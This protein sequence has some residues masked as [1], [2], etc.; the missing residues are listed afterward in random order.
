MLRA[1]SI[2]VIVGVVVMGVLWA[3][4]RQLIYF[5]GP[6]RPPPVAELLP[7]GEEVTLRTSDGLRL[8]AWLAPAASPGRGVSVLVANGNAGDR[9]L[10]AS[11]AR[12][13]NGHGLSVLLF[14]Y[15]GYGG[16]PGSPTERGLARDVRAGYR[17][18][19]ERTDDRILFYGE[20]LGAAVVTELATEHPPAGLVLR[21]PF[22][23]LAAVG[24]THYPLLPVRTLLRDRYPLIDHLASVRVPT[25]VVYGAADSIIPA[26]Q[27]RTVAEAAP[28][29]TT[30]VEI[31]GA[32]HNDRSLLDGPE[33]I[34]AVVELADQVRR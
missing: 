32:D 26:A 31:P 10:R 23:D 12:A 33:L 18:L 20:S 7:A 30:T 16:N 28:G 3:L 34:S 14:D 11:L 9:S 15:R 8:G 13:L 5:P 24:R 6:G 4:Q 19:V 27:S 2:A 1:A 22:T 21:S 17:F 25:V 29:P